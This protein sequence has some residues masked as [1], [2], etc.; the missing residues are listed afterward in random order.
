MPADPFLRANLGLIIGGALILIIFLL[1]YIAFWKDGIM[2][3]DLLDKRKK[4][5]V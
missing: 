4:P 5:A 1:M 3:K 2:S